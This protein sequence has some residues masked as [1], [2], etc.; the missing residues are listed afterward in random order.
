M[1]LFILVLLL[2][3]QLL[4]YILPLYLLLFLPLFLILDFLYWK[5]LYNFGI[6]LFVEDFLSDPN[7]PFILNLIIFCDN[8]AQRL[9]QRFA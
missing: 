9:E 4:L 3:Q 6:I 8:S 2:I 5:L 1:L 7:R